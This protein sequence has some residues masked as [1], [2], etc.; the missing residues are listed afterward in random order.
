M[1]RTVVERTTRKLKRRRPRRSGAEK[2]ASQKAYRD[3]KARATPWWADLEAIERIYEQCRALTKKT[4]RKHE[5][6]HIV[7][8]RG[9]NVSGLHVSWNLQILTKKANRSKSNKHDSN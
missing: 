6:D 9:K 1:V 5:V 3:A 4:R 8:I 7:P 2:A